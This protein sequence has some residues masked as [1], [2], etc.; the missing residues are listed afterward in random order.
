MS[1][2]GSKVVLCAY[3]L[4][5]ICSSNVS[6]VKQS[7]MGYCLFLHGKNG[8]ALYADSEK[9]VLKWPVCLFILILCNAIELINFRTP[10]HLKLNFN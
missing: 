10:P 8:Q 7:A 9:N 1:E 5:T 2:T 3:I 4:K 6:S